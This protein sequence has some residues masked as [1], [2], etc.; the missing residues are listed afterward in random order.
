M[1]IK[2]VDV[3]STQIS[4]LHR[5]VTLE[6]LKLVE[7]LYTNLDDGLFELAHRADEDH[8]RRKLFDLA[9][10]LRDSKTHL[11]HTFESRL[12]HAGQRWLSSS[13]S[14]TDDNVSLRERSETMVQRCEGHLGV[15]LQSI[16]SR[17]SFLTRRNYRPGDLPFGPQSVTTEF[18]VA[19]DSCSPGAE[20][21]QAVCAL[22]KRFVLDRLG[23]IYGQCN[24]ILQ[25]PGATARPHQQQPLQRFAAG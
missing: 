24:T 1:Q 5:W 15:V 3:R 12:D 11:L 17:T 14:E 16:A 23:T 6:I 19:L 9:R 7:G 25:T 21:E 18:L 13:G 2:N 4:E 8:A 10:V 22:F 20:A